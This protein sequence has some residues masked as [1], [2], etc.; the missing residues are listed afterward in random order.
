MNPVRLIGAGCFPVL[1]FIC[2]AT[3]A[4]CQK[5]IPNLQDS[6]HPVFKAFPFSACGGQPQDVLKL[7]M[8]QD[9]K[10][11]ETALLGDYSVLKDTVFFR[12]RFVPGA[13]LSFRIRYSCL[14]DT[15]AELYTT[16]P[17]SGGPENEVTVKE[18]YPRMDTIPENILSFCIE[19]SEPMPENEAAYRNIYLYDDR[20]LPVEQPW[21]HKTRWINDRTMVLT[22]HPGRIKKGISYFAYLGPVFERGRKY[23]LE[24]RPEVAPPYSGI[25]VQPFIK[26]FMITG[27]VTGKA[28]VLKRRL[29]LP[30]K[31]SSDSLDIVFD[32]SMDFYSVSKGI[33][34][35]N[36]T[37]GKEVAGTFRPGATDR[38]WSFIPEKPWTGN[39]YSIFF[40]KN[41]TDVC[42]NSLNRSFETRSVKKSYSRPAVQK[43]RFRLSDL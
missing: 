25:T 31:H 43:I 37:T 1:I 4:F 19:F 27:P 40:S 34:V 5:I 28:R 3:D 15:L 18:I 29:R 11:S 39:H 12:P 7:F 16:P 2:L 41:L 9:G 6:A 42:G 26:D 14:Q 36:H 20:K 38:E 35:Q 22:L 17:L 24:I 13:G 32:R 10:E 23:M 30:E 33:S 8:L 21:Y